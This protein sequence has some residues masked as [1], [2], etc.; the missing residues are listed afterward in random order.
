M[1]EL[2]GQLTST[3]RWTASVQQILAQGTNT[4]IEVGPKDVLT[5]LLKRIA[6]EASCVACGSV[7]GVQQAVQMLREQSKPS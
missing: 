4:F 7:S 5:G 2:R 6:P 1:A 3:V